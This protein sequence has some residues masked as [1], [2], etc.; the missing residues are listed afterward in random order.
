[1]F[2]VDGIWK[3]I[4]QREKPSSPQQ[5]Y[6]WNARPIISLHSDG[7]SSGVFF[8]FFLNNKERKKKIEKSKREDILFPM[9]L[10]AA[11]ATSNPLRLSTGV[12]I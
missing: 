7:F 4:V 10:K 3:Q 9:D 6:H 12:Y 11:L 1:M 8:F 2:V 5:I